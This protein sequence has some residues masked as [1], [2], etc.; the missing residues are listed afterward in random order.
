MAASAATAPPLVLIHGMSASARSWDP[1]LDLLRSA[2]EVHAVTLPGHRG[3]QRVHDRTAISSQSYVDAVELEL[4]AR[5][6]ETADLVGNSLGGWIALQLAARGRA[7]SVVCLAP[8]GGWRAGGAYDR[9]LVAQFSVA[10][11]ACKRLVLDRNA[12]LRTSALVKRLLLSGMVARP[13]RVGAHAFESIVRDVAFCEALDI[14]I[15]DS[16]AR[17]VG[18]VPRLD[19]PVLLAWSQRDRLL[20]SNASRRR[21]A[22]QIGNPEV[23]TLLGVGHVPMSDDPLLVASTILSFTGHSD[24]QELTRLGS[25]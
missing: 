19:C 24:G 22:Q 1:V 10:H 5:G 7:R 8:A 11:R 21:L 2:R 16:G 3:G 15:H 4:D 25:A 9:F 12:R 6:I 13:D 14:A 17:D 20:I 18:E 23:L